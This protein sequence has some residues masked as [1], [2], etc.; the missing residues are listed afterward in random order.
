MSELNNIRLTN[1]VQTLTTLKQVHT[2]K[3][4][5][6]TIAIKGENDPYKNMSVHSSLDFDGSR[7]DPA[8]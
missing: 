7:I 5:G 2:V 3:Q 6:S 8:Q 4:G 1:D